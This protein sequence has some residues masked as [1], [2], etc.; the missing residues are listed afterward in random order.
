MTFKTSSAIRWLKD[1]WFILTALATA[2]VAW[3]QQHE[4]V[5]RID[6]T[7]REMLIQN[8]KIHEVRESVIRQDEQIKQITKTLEQQNE[9]LRILIDSSPRANKLAVERSQDP[10]ARDVPN[11]EPKFQEAST[12]PARK[13][14][15]LQQHDQP[16]TALPR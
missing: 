6:N 4:K 2:G 7:Q 16:Q 5:N 1:H 3:G 9:M 8:Q 11:P 13:L 14:F 10:R 12:A 15:N